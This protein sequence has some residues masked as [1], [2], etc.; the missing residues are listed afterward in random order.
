MT[1]IRAAI[2]PQCLS[3]SL[4]NQK[5]GADL[6]KTDRLRKSNIARALFNI[7]KRL[8][9]AGTKPNWNVGKS[10]HQAM[11]SFQNRARMTG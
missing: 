1:P 6:F 2:C 11:T 7:A 8:G 5:L 9:G 3:K 10:I 4:R